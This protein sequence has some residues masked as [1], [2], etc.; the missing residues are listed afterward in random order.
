M[1]LPVGLNRI[2]S[3]SWLFPLF[4]VTRGI[5]RD[6]Q[7]CCF[8]FRKTVSQARSSFYSV[9]YVLSC[10]L[11]IAE[12]NPQAN[13][14]Q[15]HRDLPHFLSVALSAAPP[16]FDPVCVQS[17]CTKLETIMRIIDEYYATRCQ[18]QLNYREMK[19]KWEN[20]KRELANGNK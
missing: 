1:P 13:Q 11:T 2:I 14:S 19:I 16:F 18:L 5:E 6:L 7:F 8:L 10:F 3:L 15:R 17:L 20:L 4:L 9:N 12:R